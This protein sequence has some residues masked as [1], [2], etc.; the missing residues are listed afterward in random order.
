[1]PELRCLDEFIVGDFERSDMSQMYPASTFRG[2]KL[3]QL[4][5]FRPYNKE[6]QT[7]QSLKFEHPAL[8][9][10]TDFYYNHSIE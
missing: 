8:P 10:G 3:R 6:T 4:K 9:D 5:R 2:D 7:Y 1:M